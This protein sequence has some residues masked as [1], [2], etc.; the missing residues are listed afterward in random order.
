LYC[1]ASCGNVLQLQLL[2]LLQHTQP[3]G[4]LLS[5]LLLLLLLQG[6]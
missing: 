4:A 2:V 1:R 5:L 3:K 6:G